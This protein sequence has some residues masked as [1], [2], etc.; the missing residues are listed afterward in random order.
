MREELQESRTSAH[1]GDDERAG[2]TP[3][4][5]FQADMLHAVI[6]RSEIEEASAL[7]AV[8]MNGFARKKWASFQEAAA[9][10]TIDNCIAPCMEEK[11]LQS[12]YSGWREAVK[13]VIGQNN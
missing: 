7:G 13:K 4:F 10:R 2:R 8:V 6:N 5:V 1:L 9:M 3:A 11:E 12:L